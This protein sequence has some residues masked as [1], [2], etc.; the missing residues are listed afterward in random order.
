MAGLV[1]YVAG[2]HH[3]PSPWW[4]VP[5]GLLA[6]GIGVGLAGVVAAA[7]RRLLPFRAARRAAGPL[8]SAGGPVRRLR[9]VPVMVVDAWRGRGTLPRSQTVLWLVALVYLV[10]PLDVIADVVFPLIGIPG[11]IGLV[12]WLLATVYT[13][14]GHYVHARDTDHDVTA[15]PAPRRPDVSAS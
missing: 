6:A 15:R 3:A 9:A 1:G 5:P 14:A 4:L 11:D 7:R 13:E 12:A 10:S 2:V 8:P